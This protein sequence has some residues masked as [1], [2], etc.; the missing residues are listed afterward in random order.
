MLL[1]KLK[2]CFFMGETLNEE[3]QGR[4]ASLSRFT[5]PVGGW[6][7]GERREHGGTFKSA[8]NAV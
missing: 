6:S 7:G 3:R 5:S 8:G 4:D 2:P 1:T